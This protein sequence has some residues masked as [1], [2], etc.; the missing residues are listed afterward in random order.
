MKN[1]PKTI[2]IIM[3]GNRRWASDRNLPSIYGH[4]AGVKS[5]KKIIKHCSII[6]IKELNLFAF[7][8]ENWSRDPIEVDG[9]MKLV[10]I[11]LK[12]EIA[13]LSSQNVKLKF[14]GD[15]RKV[16]NEI[17]LLIRR[18]EKITS[19]N[20]GLKLNIAFGYSGR[21]D[22]LQSVRSIVKKA[23]NGQITLNKIDENMVENN[24]LSN[25][26]NNIDLLLRTSGEQRISNFF[27]WQLVY[28]ELIFFEKNWPDF[29]ENDFDQAL[30]MYSKRERRFGASIKISKT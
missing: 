9:I 22:I 20:T 13:E 24:L 16:R 7:S 6:N 12:S 10:E 28:S 29:D 8:E 23:L 17:K 25:N 11:Y 19:L 18:S 15:T 26:V 5:L 3:D 27:P 14:I 2:G 21:S 1:K 30:S 4:R